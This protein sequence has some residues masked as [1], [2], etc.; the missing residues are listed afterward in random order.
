MIA[1]VKP[2]NQVKAHVHKM[3]QSDMMKI[4]EYV[5][6]IGKKKLKNI[7]GTF[8]GEGKTKINSS[9]QIAKGKSEDN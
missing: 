5:R 1:A 4:Y 3:E 6:T 7:T 2:I 9:N 8:V